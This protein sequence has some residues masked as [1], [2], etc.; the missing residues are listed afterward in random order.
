MFKKIKRITAVLISLT[1]A[2]Q[3]SSVNIINADEETI[4]STDFE[5]EEVCWYAFGDSVIELSDEYS[6]SGEFS[7]KASQRTQPWMGPALNLKNYAEEYGSV[8]SVSFMAFQTELDTSLQIGATVK[9]V[10]TGAED[11][12]LNIAT[13]AVPPGEWTQIKGTVT[14]PEG[15]ENLELYIE[16]PGVGYQTST[17]Q[18][19]YI[20]DFSL[21]SGLAEISDAGAALNANDTADDSFE[22]TE[23]T[24]ETVQADNQQNN[25]KKKKKKGNATIPVL[26]TAT[27]LVVGVGIAAYVLLSKK[28]N[29][30]AGDDNDRDQLT[31]AYLKEKFDEKIKDFQNAPEKLNEKYFSICEI[32]NMQKITADFGQAHGDE[33]LVICAYLL[34]KAV[35]KHGKVYRVSNNRFVVVSDKNLKNE[36]KQEIENQKNES[37]NYEIQIA[38]G[39]SYFDKKNDGIPNVQVIMDRAET[40]MLSE[41]NKIT[42]VQSEKESQNENSE[43]FL[44]TLENVQTIDTDIK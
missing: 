25:Q 36:I 43:D 31:K 33:A 2:V 44:K 12:Y 4:Y 26:I 13:V 15:A 7:I 5:N 11:Q 20:D 28:G 16:T 19:F 10:A 22:E 21:Y 14:V 8:F 39:Y 37:K 9:V 40:M 41:K 1:A 27:L 38:F 30:S 35:D 32:I 17:F 6:N 3:I 34:K 42:A 18:N 29:S 23:S 24:E